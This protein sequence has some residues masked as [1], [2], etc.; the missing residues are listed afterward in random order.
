MLA[1]SGVAPSSWNHCTS[2]FTPRRVPNSP[3]EHKCNTP[4]WLCLPPCLI[5]C[6]DM[7]N[8]VVH[9]TECKDIWSTSLSLLTC[10]QRQKC[11]LSLNQ[12]SSKKSGSSSILFSNHQYITKH[13][14]VSAGVSLCLIR[15]L[16]EYSW[17]SFFNILC[18]NVRERS[19]SSERL[20]RDF[21]D[22]FTTESHAASTLSGHF[23]VNIMPDL[24]FFAFLLRLF[25][26]PMAWNL[27]THQ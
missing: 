27:W 12:I 10:A 21:F 11:A 3:P 19:S 20:W 23:A 22:L 5:P 25:T 18:N 1:V 9:F 24:G 15:I 7:A 4:L 8:Q 26:D 14:S 6:S 16:Y 13:F 2:R 17:K